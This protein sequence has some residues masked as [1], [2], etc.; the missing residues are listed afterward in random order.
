MESPSEVV[1]A[2][3]GTRFDYIV[4]GGGTA[5]LPVANRLSEDP[6]I[7]VGILEAGFL[8]GNDPIID[9]PRNMAMNNG[10]PKYDWMSSTSPQTGAAGRSIPVFRGKLVGGSSALNYMGWDRGSKEEYDAWKLLGDAEGGWNWDSILPFL[11]KVEDATPTSVSRDLAVEYSAS[12]NV[13]SP[14]IPAE[15]AVGVG[16]PVKLSY[17]MVYADTVPPYVKAWNALNHHTNYNPFGGDASGVYN[18]SRSIDH[19]SGKRIASA[20]AYYT[21][22]ASRT[23]LKL[24]TGAHVTKIIFQPEL[25]D[26][27]H[28]AVGVEFIVKGTVY[29]VFASKEIILSAGT[30]QTPQILELSGIG[31]PKLLREMGIQTLV[32]LPGVGN[33]LHDHAFTRIHY[34]T[35]RGIRTFDEFRNN[36]E[37]AAAEQ[38]RYERTGQ[39]WMTSNDTTTVFTPLS[40]IME[41]SALS[42]KI[43]EIEDAISVEKDKG[44]LNELM[45]EQFSI[46]LDWLKQSSVPHLEF[47]IF[48]RGLFNPEPDESYFVINTGLQHPFSRG[49]VHI[50]STDPLQQPLIDPRYLTHEFDIFSLLAAYRAIEKLAQTP[51]LAEIIEKQVLPATTLTDEEVMQYIRQGLS[52]GAH[53]MGTAAMARR[54]LRG[55]VGGDLKVHGIVNLRVADA[56]IIPL[57]V[58]AHIQGTIYAI[59]EKAAD[60]IKS[61]L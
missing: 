38:E 54:D 41:E 50:Q 21:P 4:I 53:H 7:T 30:I 48:S 1:G 16:G 18:C 25:V 52:S 6:K 22:V 45:V 37:F 27:N 11:T 42:A 5:G 8:H 31:D 34:Q 49:S 32:D 39:G 44:S 19:E 3:V 55:V 29:S 17:N 23:N 33:N 59:G 51:P 61:G 47:V 57:P 43:K 14:G 46:Q 15:V 60:L 56:S 10:N 2:F 20:S 40:K 24:L 9:V 35:Q 13:S 26:G 28:V 36:P 58:A 12:G